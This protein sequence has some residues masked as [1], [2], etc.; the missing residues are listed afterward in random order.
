M[1]SIRLGEFTATLRVRSTSDV[2]VDFTH[3]DGKTVKAVPASVRADAQARAA[4]K[5]LKAV[6]KSVAEALPVHRQRIE[7]FYLTRRTW[8]LPVWRERFL[9]HVLVGTL[10][11]RLIWTVTA[12]AG[13]ARSVMWHEG[14]LVDAAGDETTGLA[15][16]CVV[17][18]WHPLEALGDDI[19]ALTSEAS[20]QRGNSQWCARRILALNR[21]RRRAP[22]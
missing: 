13:T 5:E 11:R 8:P 22:R 20:G 3:A 9:D 2:T 16:D 19:A 7:S 6:A 12:P 17:T 14:R 21:A 4:L 10:A 18:L 15:D 1:K